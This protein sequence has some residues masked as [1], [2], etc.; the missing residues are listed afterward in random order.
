MEGV[1][2]NVES[3]YQCFLGWTAC[4]MFAM[5][6]CVLGSDIEACIKFMS[7][8]IVLNLKMF[9]LLKNNHHSISVLFNKLLSCKL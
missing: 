8:C 4:G 9:I 3:F 1:S 7:D 5:A 2:R 6:V